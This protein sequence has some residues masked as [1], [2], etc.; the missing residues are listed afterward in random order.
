MQRPE[1]PPRRPT[2][3]RPDP[4]RRGPAL[5]R[6]PTGPAPIQGWGAR[7][8]LTINLELARRRRFIAARALRQ[9]VRHS[10]LD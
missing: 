5:A 10:G 8:L 6:S 4:R 1:A 9:A 2:R 7:L 3:G